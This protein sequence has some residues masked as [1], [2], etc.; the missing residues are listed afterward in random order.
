MMIAALMVMTIAA[1]AQGE[2]G[3]FSVKP[4]IGLSL[5]SVTNL[6]SPAS[7]ATSWGSTYTPSGDI[8]AGGAVGVEAEYRATSLLG[9]SVGFLYSLQGKGF[10]NYSVD[11]TVSGSGNKIE[12]KDSKFDL[13]YII[14][15]ILANFH[16]GNSGFAIKAGLQPSFLTN[17]KAKYTSV[18]NGTETK[19]DIDVKDALKSFDLSIPIGASYEFCGG[20]TIDARYNWGVTKINKNGDKSMKNSV[21]MVTVGYNF[22]L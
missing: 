14:I 17:A 21:F 11:A 15:P 9:V 6:E 2:V 5:T 10:E 18:D 12:L 4:M 7:I 3:S 13:G 8:H 22:H 19:T 20:W 1:K 16:I